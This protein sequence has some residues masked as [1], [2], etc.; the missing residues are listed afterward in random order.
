MNTMRKVG[1]PLA[2]L[3]LAAMALAG[4]SKANT[5][6]TKSENTKS[7]TEIPLVGWKPVDYD[8]LTDG[9][10]VNLAVSSDPTG[11]GNW[12]PNTSLGANDETNQ[13]LAPAACGLIKFKSDGTWEADEDYAE[14]IK[15]V[16]E[17]PETVEVKLN[18]KAV[19][20]DGTPITADDYKATFAAL[21]G[22][23]EKFDIASSAGFEDVSSFEVVSPTDFKFTFTDAYADW[24]NLLNGAIVPAKI[25]SDPNAWSKGYVDK[26]L[27]SC[28]PFVASKVDATNHIVTYAKNPK[29]WGQAPKLDTITF[30]AMDQATQ[31]QAFTNSELNAVEVDSD[32]DGYTMAK[33]KAD[34]VVERSGGL[35]WT[36]VTINGLKPGLDD[37]AVRTAIAKSIDREL[38]AK[39]A[40]EPVGAA[41][42]TQGS[43]IFMPGQ[44][45]YTDVVG[46]NLKFDVDGAKKILTD[47]GYTDANGTWTKDGKTL[48]FSVIVPS[49]V[50][51]NKAR[52]LQIQQSL[53]AIDIP[54]EI[55]TVP[56]DDYFQK[57][58]DGDYDLA[59][60]SWVGTQFPISTA[61][62][63]FTPAG[64][65]GGD[66]QNFSFI[67]DPQL[68]GLWKQANTEL[69]EDKR[70]EIAGQIDDVISKFVPMVPFAPAPQV[71]I[72]DGN[73][74]NYGPAEF[75]AVDWT[76]VG[77]TK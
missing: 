42:E 37:V 70:A 75:Q 54:I 27:P 65:P 7:R 46:K 66:G 16:S 51:T 64:K 18:D 33:G 9:G 1:A 39:T 22:K 12:N 40:N 43:Y 58:T 45:G 61:E 34:S 21:S 56:S 77:Y 19:W 59:T 44:A 48:K 17:S 67:T 73:L 71:F 2:A 36:Q 47:A 4:C 29:W 11:N 38:M 57:I 6:D 74:A 52:A 15:L 63:L 10:T 14:S 30:K 53:K 49:G 13:V 3:G 50:D 5:A 76:E 55:Q 62:S 31:A 24:P 8:K 69:D 35:T 28:G 41:A 68:E 23:D 26:P 20:E 25:A 32:A 60:F 72:V